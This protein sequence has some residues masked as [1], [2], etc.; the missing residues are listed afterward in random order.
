[1]IKLDEFIVEVDGIKY[2]PLDIAE[3]AVAA[4]VSESKLDDAMQ[5]IKNSVKEIND[6]LDSIVDN[7]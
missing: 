1:M 3:A 4:S 5:M 7:D 2:V 6:G